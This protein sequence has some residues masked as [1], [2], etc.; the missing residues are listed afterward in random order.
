[1][2]KHINK[3]YAGLIAV[4]LTIISFFLSATYSKITQTNE[5][6]YELQVQLA[7][8]L[9]KEKHFMTYQDTSALIDKK[10]EQYHHEKSK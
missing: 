1:M 9:Q 5:R 3:V 7:S 8:I 4:L 6:V 2:E 10:I